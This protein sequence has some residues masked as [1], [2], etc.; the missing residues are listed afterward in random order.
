[1]ELLLR[2]RRFLTKSIDV[3]DP[4]LVPSPRFPLILSLSKDEGRRCAFSLALRDA[5]FRQAQEAPQD[6]GKE[7]ACA[8]LILR[9]AVDDVFHRPV[10][11]EGFDLP[12][13]LRHKSGRG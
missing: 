1:M 6:E 7:A 10:P 5:S 8:A 13:D 12:D 3:L 11:L 4:R 2:E 9:V